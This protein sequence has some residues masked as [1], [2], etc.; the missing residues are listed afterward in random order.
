MLSGTS[1]PRTQVVHQ[2]QNK[3]FSEGVTAIRQ[4]DMKLIL[5]PPGDKRVLKWPALLPHGHDPVPF[6]KTGGKVRWDKGERSC[7]SG[8]VAA[9]MDNSEKCRP[10]CLFNVT[11]DPSESENLYHI[12]PEIVD[13]LKTV[14]EVTGCKAPPP[15]KYW[16]HEKKGLENICTAQKR[17]G[18]LEPVELR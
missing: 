15:S 12:Y 16:S 17:T 13:K 4:E 3:Y 2:V 18:F 9:P 5:G 11:A 10:G 6:G 7:L 8:T 14:L 1:S